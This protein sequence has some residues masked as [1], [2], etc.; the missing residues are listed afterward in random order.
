ML[1]RISEIAKAVDAK[2]GQLL[3][4]HA[5]GGDSLLED[6]LNDMQGKVRTAVGILKKGLLERETE[7]SR[8]PRP[9]TPAL[10]IAAHINADWKAADYGRCSDR[11]DAARTL[12]TPSFRGFRLH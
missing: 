9:H 12:Q 4:D 2:H 3:R 10:H 11:A 1:E 6:P 7:V 5:A 8:H